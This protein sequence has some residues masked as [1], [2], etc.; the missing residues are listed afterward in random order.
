MHRNL[1]IF[2]HIYF[3]F[4]NF[5]RALGFAK[6]NENIKAF[7]EYSA[8]QVQSLKKILYTI[9]GLK[10]WCLFYLCKV[11]AGFSV[12]YIVGFCYHPSTLGL[13]WWCSFYLYWVFAYKILETCPWSPPESPPNRTWK[14]STGR[15]S[16]GQVRYLPFRPRLGPSNWISF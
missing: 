5:N 2:L 12:V 11:C 9:L 8:S 4:V 16:A 1:N 7:I 6:K 14:G 15:W 13:K 3:L 10:W